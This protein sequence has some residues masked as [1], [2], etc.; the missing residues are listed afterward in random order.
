MSI[1]LKDPLPIT[2]E[3]C[4]QMTAMFNWGTSENTIQMMHLKTI[5]QYHH[6]EK[7]Y[8][9]FYEIEALKFTDEWSTKRGKGATLTEAMVEF[10][11]AWSE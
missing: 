3:E 10:S 7:C 1:K 11:K 9:L 2:P 6:T 8:H 4:Q 5:K